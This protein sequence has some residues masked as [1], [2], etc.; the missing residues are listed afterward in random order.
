MMVCE[1]AFSVITGAEV[2][3]GTVIFVVGFKVDNVFVLG[4]ETVGHEEF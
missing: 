1:V 3:G 4:D 2:G